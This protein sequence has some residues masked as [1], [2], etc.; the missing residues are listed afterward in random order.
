MQPEPSSVLVVGGGIFGATA[1][2]ELRTRGHPVKL[3]DPGP[4]PHPDASSTDISKVIRADYGPDAFYAQ[5]V[6][7]CISR[8]HQWNAEARQTLY[9]ETGYLILAREKMKPGGFEHDSWAVLGKMGHPL[10]RLAPGYLARRFPSWSEEH[11]PDGYF[12]LRAGWAESADTVS[13]LLGKARDRGAEIVEGQAMATLL[14]RGSRVSGVVTTTGEEHAAGVV[15]VAAGAWTP[16]L[17]PWL[18]DALW[19]VGQPVYHFGPP[20]PEP[21]L[22][23]RF[24]PWSADIANT[25]WY[26]FPVKPDGTLKV[27]NHGDGLHVDPRS[28]KVVPLENDEKFRDFLRERVGLADAPVLRRRLC[29]Y[30]DSRD[31]DFW[32]DHDPSREGLV[33]AAGGSGH[34]FKFAPV[35]GTIVADVVEGKENPWSHRF[36][37]RASGEIRTE[38]ARYTR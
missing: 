7:E 24:P 13:W 22:P 36:R 6:G 10:E 1:A 19:S 2:L 17:L 9:H 11:Y 20:D 15:V 25:G 30:C 27:A 16:T 31:G 26:G 3:L 33:V 29:L 5:L 18:G 37:W 28:E 4:L 34:G 38:A 23:E 21:Y 14:E 32:I 12:N 35:L 8:W